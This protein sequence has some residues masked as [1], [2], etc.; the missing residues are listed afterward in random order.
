MM[1][2]GALAFSK[3][4]LAPASKQAASHSLASEPVTTTKGTSGY[5][6]FTA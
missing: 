5:L 4:K 6:A 3:N 2:L 1:V